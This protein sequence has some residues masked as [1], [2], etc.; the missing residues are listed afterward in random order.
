M[1][2]SGL[3]T[4]TTYTNKISQSDNSPPPPIYGNMKTYIQMK[5]TLSNIQIKLTH[6]III[7][8][9]ICACDKY[10]IYRNALMHSLQL[11][12]TIKVTCPLVVL[13]Y[14]N[15]VLVCP[16]HQ[17]SAFCRPH[18]APS[19]HI[20][21]NDAS[22]TCGIIWNMA[23]TRTNGRGNSLYTNAL[24]SANRRFSVV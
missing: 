10:Y 13:F 17:C 8:N 16:S 6:I 20:Y 12:I 1:V 14:S 24:S 2:I 4:Y 23:S 5:F 9:I 22:K 19:Y 3:N 15:H 21:A 11:C 18:L 7:V